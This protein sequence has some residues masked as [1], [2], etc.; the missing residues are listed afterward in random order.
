MKKAH[1]C[2]A[3]FS[4]QV[5][6]VVT[7]VEKQVEHQHH[8]AQDRN[9]IVIQIL[10]ELRPIIIQ[11]IED[12]TRIQQQSAIS[13]QV[14]YPVATADELDSAAQVE[15]HRAGLALVQSDSFTESILSRIGPAVDVELR[16]TFEQYSSQ[17]GDEEVRK[18]FIRV[19]QLLLIGSIFDDIC[20]RS[21]KKLSPC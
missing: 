4:S 14:P 1:C 10:E 18:R 7:Q 20:S 16:S 11:L 5:T 15:L 8:S 13:E 9:L 2:T 6:Q 21:W 3:C 19:K 12:Q 17:L